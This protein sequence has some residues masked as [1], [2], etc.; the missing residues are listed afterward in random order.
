MAENQ[1]SFDRMAMVKGL[2]P[3]LVVNGLLPYLLYQVL[4]AHHVPEIKALIATS[5][6]PIVWAIADWIRTRRLDVIAV[7]SLITIVIGIG[8]SLT[9]QNPTFYL[10]KESFLNAAVGIVFIL[11]LLLPRPI[12]FHVGKRFVG[13]GVKPPPGKGDDL[14]EWL[15]LER[16]AFRRGF[17]VMTVVWGVGLLVETGIQAGVAL[18]L[19]PGTVLAISPILGYGITILLMIWTFRYGAG[20]RRRSEQSPAPET[21]PAVE[22]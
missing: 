3:S 19:P 20:M 22:E 13:G 1:R 18:S 6:F 21:A 2:V 8:I 11:S 5:V 15:W 14:F 9:S 17:R 10:V 4:T 12:L 16:P 7:I